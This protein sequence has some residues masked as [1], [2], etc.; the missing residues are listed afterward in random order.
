MRNAVKENDT[1]TYMTLY[2]LYATK[3]LTFVNRHQEHSAINIER[4]EGIRA[5]T[6]E[7][8]FD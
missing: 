6:R 7:E 4:K 3:A 2:K 8:L 5:E 1:A